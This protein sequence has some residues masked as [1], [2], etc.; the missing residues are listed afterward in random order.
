M[1]RPTWVCLALLH[2]RIPWCSPP[3]PLLGCGLLAA[4][5]HHITGSWPQEAQ[6]GH[7]AWVPDCAKVSS[8]HLLR[9]RL[10]HGLRGEI[11]R[12]PCLPGVVSVPAQN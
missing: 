1:S 7:A 6:G 12:N 11:G 8:A 9:G 3:G 10:L 2:P 5:P 4:S